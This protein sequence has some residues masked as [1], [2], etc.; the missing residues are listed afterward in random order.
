M[1]VQE[2]GREAQEV[3]LPQCL[4]FRLDQEEE[5]VLSDLRLRL[6]CCRHLLVAEEAVACLW[7][8]RER[9]PLGW[10]GEAEV[11]EGLSQAL[12]P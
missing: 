2:E 6:A 10:M 7:V 5:E 12:Q 11:V 4:H 1:V 8:A 9:V 3:P